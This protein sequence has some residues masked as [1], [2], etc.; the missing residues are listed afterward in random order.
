MKKCASLLLCFVM[1]QLLLS[2]HV[3]ESP[4]GVQT[5]DQPTAGSVATDD[6]PTANSTRE[7]AP[8]QN[9]PPTESH[10]ITYGRILDLYCRHYSDSK[11]AID[12]YADELGITDTREKDLFSQLLIS[13]YLFYPGRG[14]ADSDSPHYQQSCGYAIQDLNGDYYNELILM[15]EDGSI[16]AVFSRSNGNAFLLGNFSPRKSCRIDSQ[17]RLHEYGSN[18]ADSFSHGIY[19]IVHENYEPSLR[20]IA[21]LGAD[22]S[23]WID[24]VAVT[25]YYKLENNERIRISEAE[26]HELEEQYRT[27]ADFQ[28]AAGLAFS[29]LFAPPEELFTAALKNE[30]RVC[31]KVGEGFSYLKYCETPY[32]RILFSELR[33]LQYAKVDLD[34]DTV[35]ELVV[36]CGDTLIL[37][38]HMGRICLYTFPFRDL[39]HLNTDGSYSWNQNSQ[40]FAYGESQLLFEGDQLRKKELWKIVNDGSPNAEFYVD[41]KQVTQEEILKYFEENPKTKVEF[42]PFEATWEGKISPEEA[43][44]IAD[45]YWG[46]VDGGMDRAGGKTMIERLSISEEPNP[47]SPFYRI[48]WQTEY[49]YH[50]EEGWEDRPPYHTD[51]NREVLVNIFTGKCEPFGGCDGK[52]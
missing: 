35:N 16:I 46:H 2:C 21:E 19:S 24:G 17:G 42:S 29:P 41:G 15:N 18:G 25:T 12:R 49:Y 48:V 3:N 43:L 14:Q 34:G 31:L 32:S 23:E 36:D 50:W 7:N 20:L 33:N 8:A 4:S 9:T 11:D 13:T 27:P 30:I 37:R 51:I 26:F 1:L 45:A 39:Y 22:G 5:S 40:D 38:Y 6:A 44:Q 10:T 28:E 52:G 47:F